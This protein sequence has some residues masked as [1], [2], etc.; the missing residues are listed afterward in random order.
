MTKI[1]EKKLPEGFY[2]F[3]DRFNK[4]LYEKYLEK[5]KAH[6]IKMN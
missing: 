3:W 6:R 5:K 1:V 4:D 2:D